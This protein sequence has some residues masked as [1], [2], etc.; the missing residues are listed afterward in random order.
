MC[1]LRNDS[2]RLNL[3]LSAFTSR[4][5]FRVFRVFISKQ[6]FFWVK[7]ILFCSLITIRICTFF[8]YFG[9][10]ILNEHLIVQL[11]ILQN[12]LL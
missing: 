12:K 9:I 2:L 4:F 11:L 5:R 1:N 8:L 7:N 3:L 6:L 10:D